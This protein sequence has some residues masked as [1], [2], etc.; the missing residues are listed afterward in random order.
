M[1]F[2]FY[3]GSLYTFVDDNSLSSFAKS[4]DSLVK[5]LELESYCAIEW[6]DENKI[7][8]KPDRF[9]AILLDNI[10]IIF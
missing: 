9:Q 2:F 1:F 5:V 6:F 8:V 7:I 4:I 10:K 3:I